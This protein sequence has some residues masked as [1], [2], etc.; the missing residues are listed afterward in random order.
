MPHRPTPDDTVRAFLDAGTAA[1]D[2]YMPFSEETRLDQEAQNVYATY[3]E[4]LFD[5]SSKLLRALQL[6]AQDTFYDL[7]SGTGRLCIQAFLSTYVQHVV[8]IE[9]I[10]ERNKV[11]EA[12]GARLAEEFPKAFDGNRTLRFV[13]GN[14]LNVDISD[15]TVVYTCSTAFSKELVAT[16][17]EKVKTCT[18]LRYFLSLRPSPFHHPLLHDVIAPCSW[19]QFTHC[20]IYGPKPPTPEEA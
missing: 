20:Y 13:E 10:G 9:V 7:G 2:G 1:F 16:I 5:S 15:A 3:G 4:L 12:M 6:T 17:A 11:A 14:F 19:G 18:H 8:G